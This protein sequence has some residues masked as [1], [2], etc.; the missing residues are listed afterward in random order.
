MS[1]FKHKNYRYFEVFEA[2]F[3]RWRTRPTFFTQ[4]PVLK[5]SLKLIQEFS[6]YFCHTSDSHTN[7]RFFRSP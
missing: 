5:P 1:L 4:K 2:I 7:E 6:H 3:V